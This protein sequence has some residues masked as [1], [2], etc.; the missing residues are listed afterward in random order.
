[1][2]TSSKLAIEVKERG[3]RTSGGFFGHTENGE[4]IGAFNVEDVT[5]LRVGDVAVV[6]S[7]DLLEDLFGDGARI[8]RGGGE[9]RKNH[10]A[11]SH[12]GVQ[13]RHL[14]RR[15]PCRIN[16][17]R[18]RSTKKKVFPRKPSQPDESLDQSIRERERER[19]NQL[20]SFSLCI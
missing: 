1:M 16:K 8:R 17:T 20:A 11:T 13:N 6:V 19:E 5:I 14:R 12:E 9:L 10:R 18:V 7:R 2:E 3:G 15:S 4:A